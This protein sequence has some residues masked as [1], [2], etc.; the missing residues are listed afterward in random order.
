MFSKNDY[1]KW[2]ESNIVI[3]RDQI[4]KVRKRAAYEIKVHW[5]KNIG[6]C[7]NLNS[8]IWHSIFIWLH[9]QL[10]D[11]SSKFLVALAYR[12]LIYTDIVDRLTQ[13]KFAA[14]I[15]NLLLP[16]TNAIFYYLNCCSIN[17]FF[18]CKVGFRCKMMNK[19]NIELI[20]LELNTSKC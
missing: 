10:F 4:S 11:C 1:W 20:S 5:K 3:Q 14:T 13:L 16:Y 6:C 7:N 19:L 12:I 2:D 9:Q 18:Q 8:K 15:K 17:L